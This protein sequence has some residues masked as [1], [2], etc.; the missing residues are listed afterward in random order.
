MERVIENELALQANTCVVAE[1]DDDKNN[2]AIVDDAIGVALTSTESNESQ[3][4]DAKW[5][6]TN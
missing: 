4:N 3:P 5:H 6:A 2:D 1:A